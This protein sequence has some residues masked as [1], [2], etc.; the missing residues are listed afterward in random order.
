MGLSREELAS[1]TPERA[2]KHPNW[3]MGAKVTIDSATMMNKGLEVIE[4]MHL[5]D[6]PPEKIKVVVHPQSVVHSAVE[7]ADNSVIAQMGV[8][9]MRLPIQLALTYPARLPSLAGELDLAKIGT[10]TFM[11]PDLEKFRCLKLALSV[12]GRRDAAPAVM[13][14]A[15]EIAVGAFLR[16]KIGFTAIPEIVERA[17]SDFGNMGA[18]TLEAILEADRVTRASIEV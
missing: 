9:D 2:L 16:G 17:V 18:D 15:N 11:E 1:V 10:L 7:F 5:F 3:D 14:A 8:P 6:V 12:A 13:N 4:A